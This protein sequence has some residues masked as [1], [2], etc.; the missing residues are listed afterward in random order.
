MDAPVLNATDGAASAIGLAYQTHLLDEYRRLFVVL[1]L[2]YGIICLLSMV[3]V[4]Y[5]RRNQTVA[6]Q[7]DTN[8]ARKIILPAYLPLLLLLMVVSFAYSVYFWIARFGVG[9]E[10]FSSK[11][12]TEI[13]YSGRLFFILV[14]MVFMYQKSVSGPALRRAALIALGLSAYN[15]PVVW[16]TDKYGSTEVAYWIPQCTRVILLLFYLWVFIMPPS[17]ASKRTLREYCV[18]V[19]IYYILFFAYNELFHQ[20]KM[21]PGFKMVYA[22]VLWGSLS[23][24]FIWRLL[25]ADTEHW[26]GL[27]LRA[28]ALQSIFRQKNQVNEH[29][30]SQGLHVLIE[31]HRKYIIDFAFLEFKQKIG[32]GSSAMVFQGILHSKKP[33]AIKVYTPTELT[34]EVVA[35]FSH[36]AALCGALHHPNIVQFYG[37][38]VCPPTI[39]LVSE[40]CQGSLDQV[41]Q[42]QARRALDITRQQLLIDLNYMIDATRAVAYLHSFSPAF[43]HR[44]IK[45]SNF[46][47]DNRGVVKLTDFGESR[48]LPHARGGGNAGPVCSTNRSVGGREER[49]SSGVVPIRLSH[50]TWPS[51]IHGGIQSHSER[52]AMTVRGTA[53]YMPPELI[54]GKAG[55]AMYAEA[56]DIFSLAMTLWD[57]MHPLDEKYPEANGNHL[58]VFQAVL[59]GERPPLSSATHPG[60][61]ELLRSAWDPQPE[62]RPS[63]LMILDTLEKIHREVSADLAIML[64]NAIDKK[65]LISKK[66]CTTEQFCTGQSLVQKMLEYGYVDSTEEAIRVGNGFMSA[67]LLHHGRH[68]VAFGNTDEQFMFDDA[69]LDRQH[70]QERAFLPPI[71]ERMTMSSEGFSHSLDDLVIRGA[72]HTAISDDASSTAPSGSKSRSASGGDSSSGSQPP[73]ELVRM[74]SYRSRARTTEEMRR[75]NAVTGS[76]WESAAADASGVC[77]CPKLGAGF[78]YI[79]RSTYHRFRRGKK[80]GM[81]GDG[82]LMSTPEREEARRVLGSSSNGIQRGGV[83]ISHNQSG[84]ATSSSS[85]NNSATTTSML[86]ENHGLTAHLLMN[87][88]TT[89]GEDGAFHDFFDFP[90]HSLIDVEMAGMESDSDN[91][92][93]Q[94]HGDRNDRAFHGY[95][96][97][98]ANLI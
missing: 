30:S 8:A 91:D 77:P 34:D 12:E 92:S 75:N 49:S 37:M 87:D 35:E 1:A 81:D 69:Q 38:C 47:V 9:V 64:S 41:T 50:D 89:T 56:A 17:R 13:Y 14:V 61:Q 19:F 57:I 62:R 32:T 22:N 10:H 86:D 79:P 65:I 85:S 66:G 97:Q 15:I 82:G 6:F 60:F 78:S 63:A 7:G 70:E 43:L 67:R 95:S 11:V 46:L 80:N 58:K 88:F 24:L 16:V 68:F 5:L 94:A 72:E 84:T 36:E 21:D 55:T 28:V 3:L 48:S 2:G 20:G 18:F 52:R 59:D 4:V 42:G 45:P 51:S 53:E 93:D 31:M 26:R 96:I 54:Q 33:V 23:P 98:G 83:K 29:I 27:G 73:A 44:D 39:C 40:L 71:I 74:P 76:Q 25:R 90:V